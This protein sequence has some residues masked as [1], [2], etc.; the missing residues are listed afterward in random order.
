MTLA[1]RGGLLSK[2]AVIPGRNSSRIFLV[3]PNKPDDLRPW[4]QIDR[5]A[6][7]AWCRSR[8]TETERRWNHKPFMVPGAL[9]RIV[10]IGVTGVIIK[11]NIIA[12]F[13]CIELMLNA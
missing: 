9:R 3:D 2:S 12:M 5:E 7:T 6:P 11:R 13:M 1:R 10:P 4:K 8:D